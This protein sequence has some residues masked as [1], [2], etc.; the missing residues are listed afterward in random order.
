MLEGHVR[1]EISHKISITSGRTRRKKEEE[2]SFSEVDDRFQM[3]VDLIIFTSG[4]EE[5]RSIFVGEENRRI[6]LVV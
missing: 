5:R 4:G 3:I 6:G 1:V 2:A